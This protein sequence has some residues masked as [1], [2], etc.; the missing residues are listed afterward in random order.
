MS[1]LKEYERDAAVLAA[2]GDVALTPPAPAELLGLVDAH[3]SRP[4]AERPISA[5]WSYARWKPA[6][7]LTAGFELAWPDGERR[8]VT[9]KRYAD[10]KAGALIGRRERAS[11]PEVADDRLLEH[12]VLPHSGAHL[13]A[14][15]YDRE[16]PG[17]ER[18]L[19]LRR[20][21]RW[22]LEQGLFA[23]RRVRSKSSQATLLRYKPERRAVLRLDLRLRPLQGGE[24]SSETLGARALPLDEARRVASARATWQALEPDLVA[25]RLLAFEEAAGLLY[26]T[27]L[28]LDPARAD[29]LDDAAAAGALLARLHARAAPADCAPRA[30]ELSGALELLARQPGLAERARR[31]ASLGELAAAPR[32]WTH[33]DFHPDQLARGRDGGWCLLDLDRLGAGTE[34]ADLSSWIADGLV[35]GRARDFAHAGAALLEGYE[36]AGGA[37]P[38]QAQ[39]RL[40]VARELVQRA[41][42]ALRRLEAE[43]LRVAAQRVDLALAIAP[44]GPGAA[45]ARALATDV[46]A[47]LGVERIELA[48]T[49][50]LL[51]ELSSPQEPRWA[52]LGERGLEELRLEEDTALPLCARVPPLRERGPVRVLAWRPGRRVVIA[53]E[54]RVLKGFRRGRL[55]SSARRHAQGVELSRAAGLAAPDLLEVDE[56]ACAL[57]MRHVAGLRPAVAP[58]SSAVFERLG[59][60]LARFQVQAPSG[61]LTRHDAAAELAVLDELVERTRTLFGDLPAGWARARAAV[62]SAL[63][64][65]GVGA[66]VPTHR[67]LHDGQVLADAER[68]ALLDFDL[69]CVADAALDPANLLAHLSLRELQGLAMPGGAAA[70]SG[71]FRCGLGMRTGGDAR[72]LDAWQAVTF[73]RLALVYRARPPWVGL[74]PRLISLSIEKASEVPS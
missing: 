14:P 70:C 35:S 3:L 66:F 60:G 61:E 34:L 15:P 19:D 27:W 1:G 52:R 16:L 67:D 44:V 18:A 71:A 56:E 57:V 64:R 72:R 22:F 11:A 40:A 30:L 25:P 45:P 12:C 68:T 10:G 7:S 43:A 74:C 46:P 62:E 69:L 55:E 54:G 59:A 49:G 6:T 33:G 20:A 17:L 51:L 39:L 32:V 9:W 5:R 73:A 48:R 31:A 8:W 53:V 42:G 36:R 58:A 2:A 41:A 47:G 28:E 63:T 26:E 37:P 4:G 65:A 21:K 38:P 13:W 29:V 50:G 23:G 24:K